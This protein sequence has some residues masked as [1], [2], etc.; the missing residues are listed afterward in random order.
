MKKAVAYFLTGTMVLSLTACLPNVNVSLGD[1][2]TNNGVANLSG[3][4]IS[5]EGENTENVGNNENGNDENQSGEQNTANNTEEVNSNFTVKYE[6]YPQWSA[7]DY[8]VDRDYFENSEGKSIEKVSTEYTQIYISSHEY[9]DYQYKELADA[10]Q[11]INMANQTALMETFKGFLSDWDEMF[12][13]TEPD[14]GPALYEI[15]HK[16]VVRADQKVFSIMCDSEAYYG[17]A[18]G[19]N[20]LGSH[21]LYS[22]T[23]KEIAFEDVVVKT[24]GLEK[25][26]V[27]E[28]YDHY[29]KEI[30]FEETR[31]GLEKEVK[32]YLDT[33]IGWT[34]NN[35]GVAFYFGDY[36]LAA[37]ASG[38]QIVYINFDKY[39]EYL[40]PEFF[41][42]ADEEYVIHAMDSVY[43]PMFFNGEEGNIT[44]NWERSYNAEGDFYSETYQ[45]LNVYGDPFGYQELKLDGSLMDPAV[46]IVRK[47]NNDYLY[48]TNYYF[49]GVESLQVFEYKNG[50][51]EEVRDLS[52]G[53]TFETS[54]LEE[55]E[56]SANGSFASNFA[57]SHTTFSVGDDGMPV[58]GDVYYYD[59]YDG[60]QDD[61]YYVAK[62]DIKG[63]EMGS[64]G[65]PSDKE[66]T[67][68]KGTKLYPFATDQDT[69]IVLVDVDDNYYAFNIGWDS[70]EMTINKK[71]TY[72]LFE[73]ES[74]W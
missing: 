18:H 14:W 59:L 66:L 32:N 16:G 50:Q 56:F 74:N 24:D 65:K 69:Y 55:V 6:G 2:D 13:E 72:S 58:L 29:D 31:E 17:G 8:I 44:F 23:G 60:W 51:F 46:Y 71:A 52:G 22:Q 64:D 62:S 19:G 3:N 30:F 63:F 39:P 12:A 53:I 15:D 67:L 27:D 47:N 21:N 35:F 1:K 54:K 28:L 68:K 5:G 36:A 37:Y 33:G 70:Y 10:I 34:I 20:Y 42:D 45:I 41:K 11:E 49:D 73:I 57:F 25:I 26:I 7:Y 48:V 43:L 9:N 4:D 38:H 40:N 61:Y